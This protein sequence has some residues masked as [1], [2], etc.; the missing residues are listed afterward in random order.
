MNKKKSSLIAVYV[1]VLLVYSVIFFVI[2]IPKIGA[3]WVAY[4]FSVL[5]IGIAGTV[6]YFV[7]GKD[8]GINSKF[9][10]FPIFRVGNLYALVQMLFGGLIT[11][12]GAFTAVAVWIVMVISVVLL[13][14]AGIGLI[15]TVNTKEIIERQEEEVAHQTN[16]M[17]FFELNIESIVDKCDDPEVKKRVEELAEKFRYSDPVSS[18]EL[19][20]IENRLRSEVE[21][22]EVLVMKEKETA[23][24]KIMEIERLLDNRNRKCK[25]LKK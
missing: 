7:Y 13:G 8:E 21:I 9:Y 20:E 18:E 4:G 10:G 23:L 2:P 22:L 17:K 14:M 6:T 5:S 15:A 19:A 24:K 25:A 1:I 3:S 16:D 12:I 11:I